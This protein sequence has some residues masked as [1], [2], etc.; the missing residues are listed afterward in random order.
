MGFSVFFLGGVHLAY[1]GFVLFRRRD[2]G[3]NLLVLAH[4]HVNVDREAWQHGLKRGWQSLAG[5]RAGAT[6]NRHKDDVH[7]C[8]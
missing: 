6:K 5:G 3:S 1:C 4:G 7:V 2:K 8:R